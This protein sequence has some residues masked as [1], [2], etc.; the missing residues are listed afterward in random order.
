MPKLTFH[1]NEKYVMM[2][3]EGKYFYDSALEMTHIS[4]MGVIANPIRI[5]IAKLLIDKP[6][7][8]A[9]I[10]KEINLHEQI[11]YYHIKQLCNAGIIHEVDKKEIR[12]TTA[13]IYSTKNT[14]FIASIGSKWKPIKTITHEKKESIEKRFLNQFISEEG[15]FNSKIIVGSPDPTAHSKREQEM[16]IMQ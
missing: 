10:A 11:V 16:D 2:Q 15:I 4:D 12:G 6:M 8:P 14:N 7:Y 3:K 1:M 9:Q 13:K 5:K